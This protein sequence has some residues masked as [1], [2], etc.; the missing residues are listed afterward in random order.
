[1]RGRV[2]E[3]TLNNVAQVKARGGGLIGLGNDGDEKLAEASDHLLLVPETN[4]HLTPVLTVVPLQLLAYHLADRRG[5]DVDQ[6]R[7]L[8]KSVTVE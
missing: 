1:V 4:E 8:A 2:Y 6:P 5:C 3:K 7:N